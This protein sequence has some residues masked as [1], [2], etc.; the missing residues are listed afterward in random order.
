M[1]L[2]PKSFS[3]FGSA[4]SSSRYFFQ[5]VPVEDIDS[6]KCKIRLRLLRFLLEFCDLVVIVRYHQTETG[7]LLSG[8]FH[9]RNTELRTFFLVE[10]Q[11][12]TVILLTNLISGE[13][14]HILRIIAVDK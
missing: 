13:D 8:H 12:I 3:E 9:D 11:E 2:F 5:D 1:I 7:R 10:F 4:S 6:H 14:D